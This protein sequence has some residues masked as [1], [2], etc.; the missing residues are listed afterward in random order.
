[1]ATPVIKQVS[2]M[3]RPALKFLSGRNPYN[4]DETSSNEPDTIDL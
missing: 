2:D 3:R 4:V 1:M